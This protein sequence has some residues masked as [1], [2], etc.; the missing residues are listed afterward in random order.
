MEH[1]TDLVTAILST[2]VS[3]LWLLVLC[4]LAL[5]LLGGRRR[6]G[7]GRARALLHRRLASG[8]ISVEEYYEREA[9][10]RHAEPAVRPRRGLR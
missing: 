8:E 4:W 10:L 2:G 6:D 9:A 1:G 3:V 5:R 7:L